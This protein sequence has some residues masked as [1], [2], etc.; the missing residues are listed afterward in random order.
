MG[1]ISAVRYSYPNARVRGMLGGLLSKKEIENAS[2]S[3]SL[4]EFLIFLEGSS[5]KRAVYGVERVSARDL[6][7]ILWKDFIHS[8]RKVL[9]FT[10]NTAREF[11]EERVRYWDISLLRDTISGKISGDKSSPLEF[12]SP[13]L[14]SIAYELERSNSV[15][16]LV[17][18]MEN[19]R[20]GK[21]LKGSLH[22]Y[23]EN[24]LANL[25]A[26]PLDLFHLENLWKK[27]EGLSGRDREIA[28]ILVG[29]EIDSLNIMIMLRTQRM[30]GLNPV[31][32]D[33]H[34]LLRRGVLEDGMKCS[35]VE[36][37]IGKLSGTPYYSALNSGVQDFQETNSLFPF[38]RALK[39]LVMDK[40]RNALLGD[41]FHLGTL[42]GY[43][44]LKEIEITN[45]RAILLG[46][47][48]GLPQEDIREVMIA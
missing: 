1:L 26:F 48:N 44:K 31:I 3:S 27:A 43:L 6:E 45:L 5:Y 9:G 19:T 37:I 29:M 42:L 33:H 23:R 8:C 34:Y 10:P 41:P 21:L 22:G 25:F 4:E 38:E 47:E 30:E 40:N 39:I 46:I 12:I 14:N 28:R 11:M 15:E 13:E 36:E 17:I 24:T 16:E 2:N 35:A 20:Y 18:A 7:I 32:I